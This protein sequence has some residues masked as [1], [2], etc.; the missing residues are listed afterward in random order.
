M[1]AHILAWV[2]DY[3]YRRCQK[4]KWEGTY[5]VKRYQCMW[6]ET[7]A[8]LCVCLYMEG[9][10]CVFFSRSPPCV[11]KQGFTDSPILATA[12]IPHHQYHIISTTASVPQH[13][14]R[15]SRGSMGPEL[16]HLKAILSHIWLLTFALKNYKYKLKN[17]KVTALLRIRLIVTHS[18]GPWVNILDPRERHYYSGQ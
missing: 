1:S 18:K 12:S 15:W 6:V 4:K 2:S 13:Q 16:H 3:P 10:H 8:A 9:S 5:Y 7:Y 11:L 17:F 14:Y